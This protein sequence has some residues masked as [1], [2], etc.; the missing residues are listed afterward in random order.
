MDFGVPQGSCLGLLLFTIYASKLFD[1]IKVH[2][3][4]VH[5]YADDKQLYVSFS[6]NISTGQFEAFTAIQHCVD[7]IRNRMTNDKQQ[8]PLNDDN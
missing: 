3:F 6:P 2:L 1:V 7:D 5:C 8:L 4:T